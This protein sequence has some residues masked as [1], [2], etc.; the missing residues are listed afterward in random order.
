MQVRNDGTYDIL[1]RA[2][3]LPAFAARPKLIGVAPRREDPAKG[4]GGIRRSLCTD[5]VGDEISESSSAPER[6]TPLRKLARVW[7]GRCTFR[8]DEK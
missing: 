7:V 3:F 8:E 1:T 5:V 4:G 6:L 2:D